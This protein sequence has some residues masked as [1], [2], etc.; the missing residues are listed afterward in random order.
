MAQPSLH[1][2]PNVSGA[3][4]VGREVQLRQRGDLRQAAIHERPQA[5]VAHAHIREGD[6]KQVVV[7]RERV[8]H[9]KVHTNGSEALSPDGDVLRAKGVGLAHAIQPPTRLS[10][11]ALGPAQ[12]VQSRA[13]HGRAAARRDVAS[14]IEAPGRIQRNIVGASR[15][16]RRTVIEP[17]GGLP[18][19]KS[20]TPLVKGRRGLNIPMTVRAT[21]SRGCRVGTDPDRPRMGLFSALITR[22]QAE[23]RR[24]GT[25]AK[26]CRGKTLT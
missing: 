10:S 15:R 17:I 20:P 21:D 14:E 13:E 4:R 9:Q 3:K 12:V 23:I 24:G 16:H 1:Q 2:M 22:D 6:A 26:T 25:D 7:A 19:P 5:Q 8:S 18:L 11:K